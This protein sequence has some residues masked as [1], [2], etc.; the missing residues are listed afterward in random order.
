M[1]NITVL[2]RLKMELSNKDYFDD[3]TYVQFLVEN[4]LAPDMEYIKSSMQEALLYTCL[5][6]LEAVANDIDIM[7]KLQT[8]FLTQ[9][10]AYEYVEQRIQ[11]I[12]NR[13]ASLPV[14][15]EDYSPFSL[16]YA[17]GVADNTNAPADDLDIQFAVTDG[18]LCASVNG[19]EWQIL[20]DMT[21][22]SVDLSNY[23]TKDEI[24]AALANVNVDLSAYSTTKEVASLIV[25]AISPFISGEQ[26]DERIMAAVSSIEVPSL[27]GYATETFVT[28][29]IA[30]A[31]LGGG[32]GSSVDLSG[33]ATKDDLTAYAKKEELPSTD[34]FAPADHTHDEYLTEHQDLSNYATKA[35]VALEIAKID[36][37]GSGS[38]NVDLSNYY[39]KSEVDEKVANADVDLSDYCTRDEVSEM[40]ADAD[41]VV[42]D[43]GARPMAYTI[44]DRERVACSTVDYIP[45]VANTP[46][47]L[48]SDGCR[49]LTNYTDNYDLTDYTVDEGTPA[50]DGRIKDFI[51][52]TDSE[53]GIGELM[54]DALTYNKH[55]F[56]V[57]T[58]FRLCRLRFDISYDAVFFTHYDS[59]GRAAGHTRRHFRETL[60]TGLI[61][62]SNIYDSKYRTGIF[63]SASYHDIAEKEFPGGGVA[64]IENENYISMELLDEIPLYYS[65]CLCPR[66]WDNTGWGDPIYYTISTTQDKLRLLALQDHNTSQCGRLQGVANYSFEDKVYC[67]LIELDTNTITLR[68][69]LDLFDQE[70]SM[71]SYGLNLYVLPEDMPYINVVEGEASYE[72]LVSEGAVA[73]K[74]RIEL[75]DEKN[76]ETKYHWYV[77]EPL[78][79]DN[80]LR[81]SSDVLNCGSAGVRAIAKDIED[82]YLSDVKKLNG[83]G[84]F[85]KW[86]TER[87][88]HSHLA[89]K[90]E[91]PTVMSSLTNDKNYLRFEVVTA[92]PETQEEGVLYIV[93]E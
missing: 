27:E 26:V 34:D 23:Y 81:M 79:K 40:V 77:T 53:E 52:V 1:A 49:V 56:D 19:G 60:E 9:D 28:N 7:R 67:K 13:I 70:V 54:A 86:F 66:N 36:T 46:M 17:D 59:S 37:S 38:T 45:T 47:K 58:I 91:I 85:D 48:V 73:G 3:A 61:L 42:K 65:E 22:L 68:T 14:A 4:D 64:W 71:G 8:D 10:A 93:I 74:Y 75:Y 82:V 83:Y 69:G 84:S 41:V 51:V 31:Q 12:K 92:E 30:A 78:T 80:Y 43:Y 90:E 87:T 55:E 15:Q 62:Y 18:Y 89:R 63:K 21:D 24:N 76:P 33:F 5:D 35:Y 44:E 20:M 2:N 29:A 32:D 57:S 6:I 16:V 88:D 72:S 39:T 11:R 50:A 25:T